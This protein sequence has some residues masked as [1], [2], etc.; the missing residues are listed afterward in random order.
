MLHHIKCRA[1]GTSKGVIIPND[2]L[3]TAQIS[4]NDQ[5]DIDYSYQDD[6]III[7]K[8][9]TVTREGWSEAFKRLHLSGDDNLLID[10]V[11]EDEFNNESI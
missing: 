11:F 9:R 5:L 4:E 10:D 2:L 8:T 1:I 3:K 7:R 6:A